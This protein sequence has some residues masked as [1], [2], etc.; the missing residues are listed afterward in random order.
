MVLISISSEKELVNRLNAI[1]FILK[2]MM[3]HVA[4][5]M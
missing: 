4:R 3:L 2:M 5:L 1:E